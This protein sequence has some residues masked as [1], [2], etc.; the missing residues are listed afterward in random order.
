MESTPPPNASILLQKTVSDLS[1]SVQKIDLEIYSPAFRA[2]W[3]GAAIISF[4]KDPAF[5][6][7]PEKK[8]ALEML[9]SLHVDLFD[10]YQ[11]MGR[12]VL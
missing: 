12:T 2:Q 4:S 5:A 3:L 1:E 7:H 6:E 10:L 11:T 9:Q 8:E